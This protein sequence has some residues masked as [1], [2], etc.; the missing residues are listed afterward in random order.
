M[1]KLDLRDSL[2]QMSLVLLVIFLLTKRPWLLFVAGFLLVGSLSN[3]KFMNLATQLW[4]QLLEV[5]S[6]VTRTILL[7]TLFYIFLTPYAALF[8]FAHRQESQ[9]FLGP[10]KSEGTSYVAIDTPYASRESF[11]RVW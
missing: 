5:L 4:Q 10:A 6:R 1:P 3:W 2:E 9:R 7:T 11:E 8:R